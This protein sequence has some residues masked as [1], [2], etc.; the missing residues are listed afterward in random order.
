MRDLERD[1]Q[2]LWYSNYGGKIPITDEYGNLTG[3]YEITRANPL[4]YK[5]NIRAARGEVANRQFGEE[6]LYERVIATHDMTCPIT[7]DS[8]LWIDSVPQLDGEG[9]LAIDANG[10]A[11][12]PHNYV[13]KR[14]ARSL[15]NILIAIDKVDV[16]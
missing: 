1:Q 5:A 10:D 2:T 6:E 11:I 3:E 13:V 16:T 4:P 8:V 15:N 14:V 7:E 12:T 9:A